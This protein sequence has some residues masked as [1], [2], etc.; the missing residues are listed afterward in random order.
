MAQIIDKP[1][2]RMND[3]IRKF[4]EQTKTQLSQNFM[5]QHIWPREAYP[6]YTY[7]NQLRK[8]THSWYS[9]GQGARSFDGRVI[10]A[11]EKNIT[12][13][14]SY[15]YYLRFAELGVGAGVK[16][17]DVDRSKPARYGQRYIT[18]WNRMEGES[19]RPAILME[20]RHLKTRIKDYM[21]DFYMDECRLQFLDLFDGFQL[22]YEF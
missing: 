14:F 16:A 4:T 17:E 15:L 1:I 19:H 8:N 2:F 13:E 18:L 6:G 21:E 12:V 5:T 9:T 3:V 22:D 11:D 10:Q 20:M 7:I